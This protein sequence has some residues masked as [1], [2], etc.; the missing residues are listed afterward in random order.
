MLKKFVMGAAAL[1]LAH[2]ANAQL[3]GVASLGLSDWTGGD[4]DAI[5]D[6][7]NE[8]DQ[9]DTA[10]KLLG[11][12]KLTPQWA[13]EAGYWN[14]GSLNARSG[15]LTV[16]TEA[17]AIGGGLAYHAQFSPKWHGAA[18]LGLLSMQAKIFNNFGQSDD[19]SSLQF[20]GGLSLGYSVAPN[21]LLEGSWDISAA[22]IDDRSFELNA[23][24][25]GVRLAF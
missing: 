2:G 19:E 1:L 4:A 6:G 22:E 21:I 15:V 12:F 10:F 25:L 17:W 18:R 20:Y 14:Y 23:L 7:A 16:T 5:C 9:E 13:A 8:C 24:S 11:G 3:Y